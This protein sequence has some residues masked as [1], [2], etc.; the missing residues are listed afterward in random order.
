VWRRFVM[1]AAAGIVLEEVEYISFTADK[2]E[3]FGFE[4]GDFARRWRRV[5]GG[6]Q[7]RLF[8]G[9]NLT[10]EADF[11]PRG[12]C[13]RGGGK[14]V[15]IFLIAPELTNGGNPIG[16]RLLWIE[17][18]TARPDGFGQAAARR[19]DDGNAGG[20]GFGCDTAK[21][22]FPQEVIASVVR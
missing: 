18:N 5:T 17:K 1:S 7:D 9:V 20:L 6:V 21:G 19:C 3:A 2:L 12:M 16:N 11:R 13:C 10:V 14:L 4:G 8:E 15:V 22:F